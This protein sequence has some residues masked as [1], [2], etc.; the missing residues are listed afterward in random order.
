MNLAGPS[1]IPSVRWA[2]LLT[3]AG[4]NSWLGITYRFYGLEWFRTKIGVFRLGY[5]HNWTGPRGARTFEGG[6]E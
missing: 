2:Y 6:T 4:V 5:P 3:V 1:L